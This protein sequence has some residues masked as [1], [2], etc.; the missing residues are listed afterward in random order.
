MKLNL[1]DKKVV[2]AFFNK[3]TSES[4][5]FISNGNTLTATWGE[6]IAEWKNDAVLYNTASKKTKQIIDQVIALNGKV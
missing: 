2:Q 4:R 5:C 3:Q 6:Q 1:A